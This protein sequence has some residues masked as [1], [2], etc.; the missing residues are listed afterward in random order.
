[1][2]TIIP[3]S[4][5]GNE[6]VSVSRLPAL[7]PRSNAVGL[8]A[9]ARGV[10]QASDTSLRVG[11]DMKRKQDEAL[12][13]DAF[14]KFEISV[15]QDIKGDF[16]QRRGENAIGSSTQ[17]GVSVLG[18]QQY[19][20]RMEEFTSG[21][22]NDEQKL[23]FRKAALARARYTREALMEHEQRETDSLLKNNEDA[24]LA[25]Q[26]EFVVSDTTSDKSAS[27][28]LEELRGMADTMSVRAGVPLDSE[29]AEFLRLQQT[30]GAVVGRVEQIAVTNPDRALAFYKQHKDK[31]AP[32]AREGVEKVIEQNSLL[33]RA[34]NLVTPFIQHDPSV[35]IDLAGMMSV[36]NAESDPKVREM[37][38]AQGLQAYNIQAKVVQQYENQQVDSAV[39]TIDSVLRARGPGSLLGSEM[40]EVLAGVPASERGVVRSYAAN[41]NEVKTDYDYFDAYKRAVREG[42]ADRPEFNTANLNARLGKPERKTALDLKAAAEKNLETYIEQDDAIKNQTALLEISP[43]N[44]DTIAKFDSLARNALNAATAHK[45]A[46]LSPGEQQDILT[47]AS[48]TWTQGRNHLSYDFTVQEL[49]DRIRDTLPDEFETL[50]GVEF[51]IDDLSKEVSDEMHSR[52]GSGTPDWWGPQDTINLGIEMISKKL[53]GRR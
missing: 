51:K 3:K 37:A 41:V 36:I 20:K 18:M 45:K 35:N 31:V 4:L 19:Q 53:G 25:L 15:L 47:A 39:N 14:N 27:E 43:Y 40:A 29:T 32:S 49:A 52:F 23:A 8:E 44:K 46:R 50:E 9:S 38:S 28:G 24:R 16:L 17:P 5:G 33:V 22:T 42:T 34:S 6:T 7:I 1:M 13:L 30:T 26:R 2:A 11:L 12:T 10:E 48:I 21:L